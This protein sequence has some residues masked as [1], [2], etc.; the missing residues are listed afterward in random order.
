MSDAKALGEKT[1]FLGH[2]KEL[3]SQ[4]RDTFKDIWKESNPGMYVAEEKDKDSYVLCGS[5]Q[6]HF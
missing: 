2:T 3:I 4:A 5:V 1:L 6:K